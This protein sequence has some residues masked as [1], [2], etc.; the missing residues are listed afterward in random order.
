[1]KK[2]LVVLLALFTHLTHNAYAAAVAGAGAGA[3]AGA[4]PHAGAGAGVHAGVMEYA[5]V[6]YDTLDDLEQLETSLEV[7]LSTFLAF[8]G[9]S[10]E[11]SDRIVQKISDIRT[12]STWDFLDRA[13]KILTSTLGDR[14]TSEKLGHFWFICSSSLVG[15]FYDIDDEEI[16]QEDTKFLRTPKCCALRIGARHG[17]QQAELQYCKHLLRACSDT[18]VIFLKSIKEKF[19]ALRRRQ[20][21]DKVCIDIELPITALC[22]AL[23]NNGVVIPDEEW[24]KLY[25]SI[26]SCTSQDERAQTAFLDFCAIWLLIENPGGA[27]GKQN[28]SLISEWIECCLLGDIE[29]ATEY[30]A[31]KNAYTYMLALLDRLSLAERGKRGAPSHVDASS[32]YPHFFITLQHRKKHASLSP[33]EEKALRTLNNRFEETYLP[34]LTQSIPL[35]NEEV[36][37]LRSAPKA[38]HYMIAQTLAR[39]AFPRITPRPRS[40]EEAK[41]FIKQMGIRR[42]LYNRSYHTIQYLCYW[43]PRDEQID[44]ASLGAFIKREAARNSYLRETFEKVRPFYFPKA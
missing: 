7:P 22:Y 5:G 31:Q 8:R 27:P 23:H 26:S 19:M 40:L 10:D 18:D 30:Y 12:D 32:S 35:S 4:S 3:G 21:H 29:C 6:G 39:M 36:E 14:T 33:V 15:D 44:T 24:R 20:N 17:N 34:L 11:Q 38:F 16:F 42:I 1:M 13:D 37:K 43:A 25:T 28:M 9:L 41:T 2:L